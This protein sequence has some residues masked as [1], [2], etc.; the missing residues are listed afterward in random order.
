MSKL[1]LSASFDICLNY[2]FAKQV[3]KLSAILVALTA[4]FGM[5]LWRATARGTAAAVS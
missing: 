3:R 2:H 1:A 5:L 4:C